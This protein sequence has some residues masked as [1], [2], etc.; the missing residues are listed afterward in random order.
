MP[1]RVRVLSSRPRKPKLTCWAASSG[2]RRSSGSSHS[3]HSMA[4]S[5]SSHKLKNRK[6][7]QTLSSSHRNSSSYRSLEKA[8]HGS[9]SPTQSRRKHH[10]APNHHHHH[11]HRHSRAIDH[12]GG[13]DPSA[14]TGSGDGA[15]AQAVAADLMDT[16][17]SP[18]YINHGP[19]AGR[20]A[21]TRYVRDKDKK[22]DGGAEGGKRSRKS[23]AKGAKA[24][25]KGEQEKVEGKNQD[26]KE[27]EVDAEEEK[28]GRQSATKATGSLNFRAV[29]TTENGECVP[30]YDDDEVQGNKSNKATP[31][32]RSRSSSRG[33][34]EQ[35]ASPTSV[36]EPRSKVSSNASKDAKRQAQGALGVRASGT[37]G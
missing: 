9:E 17:F 12:G 22:V 4:R 2:A 24:P 32:S 6:S 14:P 31:R 33:R 13:R 1:G 20:I 34:S 23:S 29:R 35:S 15:Y 19:V 11:H 26:G 37:S 27:S 3:L 28:R 5:S 16:L 25:M 10:R 18:H 8:S 7:D 36:D 30:I 21:S